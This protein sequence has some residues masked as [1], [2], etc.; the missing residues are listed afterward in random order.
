MR[1]LCVSARQHHDGLL[2]ANTT[3]TAWC[4]S[5]LCCAVS[6]VVLREFGQQHARKKSWESCHNQF[7]AAPRVW[8]AAVTRWG[9]SFMYVGKTGGALGTLRP[10]RLQID[11]WLIGGC[12]GTGFEADLA[13]LV[14][15]NG[16][17]ISTSYAR[18]CIAEAGGA[19]GH[20]YVDTG[21]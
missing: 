2:Q 18:R 10:G 4:C 21:Y 5:A 3:C 13:A 14:P 7:L 11:G 1:R 16:G 8:N 19:L 9:V 12:G 17:T 6:C 20:G 15:Q